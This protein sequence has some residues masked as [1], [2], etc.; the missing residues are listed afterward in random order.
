MGWQVI[1]HDWAVALLRRS[2][3]ANRVAHAYLFSGPPH[4]GK[5]RLALEL[6]RALNCGDSEPPCG[7]CPSCLRIAQGTHPDVRIVVG[8]GAGESIKIEQVRALQ[9][10]AALA[11]YEGRH[12]VLILRRVDLASNEAANSLLKTLEEPPAHVVLALTAVHAEG[13]PP[14]VVSRCQRLE[15]RPLAHHVIGT[16]LV[17]RGCPPAQAQLLA[18]LSGGRI[19]W[20]LSASQDDTLLDERE[21]E[22]DQL[23]VL[24]A[25]D[26]V[27]RIKFALESSRDPVALQRQIELWTTWWRDLLLMCC[28]NDRHIVNA[29]C[30]DSLRLLAK[31]TT[32]SQTWRMLRAL[33]ATGE[34]LA[35]NV[36]RRL[37]L[38]GLLLKLSHLQ[39]ERS[40]R[41]G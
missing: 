14:T 13:L 7:Q 4:I 19:G 27:D 26:R 12:R 18:R 8:E 29:D 16:A 31:Q 9:R 21:R 39:A 3:A 23:H 28:Q 11:P 40:D 41:A 15:L 33:E 38:E 5:T 37:S 20:A 35:A 25:A 34:Q 32:L 17:E 6:A 2:L 22:L 24:L 30:I 1:G 10:E 36:N